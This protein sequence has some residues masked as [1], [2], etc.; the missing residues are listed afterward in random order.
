MTGFHIK[1]VGF[2]TMV[3]LFR[4][5]TVK[6]EPT[7]EELFEL[8]KDQFVRIMHAT[9]VQLS[10]AQGYLPPPLDCVANYTTFVSRNDY[11]ATLSKGEWEQETREDYGWL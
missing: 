6:P 7:L 4:D 2:E 1:V 8:G 9:A 11:K 5:A 3:H 10:G